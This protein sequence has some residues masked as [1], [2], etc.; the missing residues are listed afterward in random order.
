MPGFATWSLLRKENP[1][2]KMA[3]SKQK[4]LKEPRQRLPHPGQARKAA[5]SWRTQTEHTQEKNTS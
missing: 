4:E 1:R 5:G 3:V 2:E